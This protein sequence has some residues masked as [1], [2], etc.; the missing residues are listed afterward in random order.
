MRKANTPKGRKHVPA[1]SERKLPHPHR[2]ALRGAAHER[3][4]RQLTKQIAIGI[5]PLFWHHKPDLNRR[6]LS[7]LWNADSKKYDRENV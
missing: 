6:G 1:R 5:D 7:E 4:M 3:M 2:A